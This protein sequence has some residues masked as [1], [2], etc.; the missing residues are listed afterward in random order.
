MA[1]VVGQEG[2]EVVPFLWLVCQG[3][4]M[5]VAALAAAPLKMEV[6]EHKVLSW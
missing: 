1:Q 5:V 4:I 3:P 6:L 2:L